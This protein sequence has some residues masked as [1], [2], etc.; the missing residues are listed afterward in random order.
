VLVDEK[1][2]MT[3]QCMLAA[4]KSNYILGCIKRSMASRLREAILTVSST[5]LRHTWSPA[6]SS[7]ALKTEQTWS[8]WS[9]T[10]GGP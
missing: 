7:G 8:C 4:Q 2:N 9:D 1:L 3:Q 6:S 5:L 10:R